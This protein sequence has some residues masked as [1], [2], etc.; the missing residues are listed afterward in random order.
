VCE[1]EDGSDIDPSL[2]FETHR[3]QPGNTFAQRY[4]KRILYGN[5]KPLSLLQPTDLANQWHFEAVFDYGEHQAGSLAAPTDALARVS[6]QDPFSTY[7]PGFERRTYRL[8]RRVLMFHRFVEL[9][10]AA[11]LVGATELTHRLDPAGSVLEKITYQGYRKDLGTGT[12]DSRSVP[13]LELSYSQAGMASSF[14]VPAYTENIPLG[15]DGT[16]YQ[17][18]DLQNEGL[19]GIL[20]AQH[21]SWRFKENLGDGHFGPQENV[22]ELPTAVSAAFQLQDFDGDGNLNLVGFEGREAGYYQHDRDGRRWE[23]FRAFRNL[24]RIDFANVGV[25]WVDLN[26]DRHPDLIVDRHERLVWYPSEGADGFSAPIE[27]AKPDVRAGGAPTLT[28]NGRL[29]TFFADMTGDGLLDMVCVDN[30]RIRYWPNLGYAAFGKAVEMEDA[31]VIDGIDQFD[32]QRIRFV[33]LDGSGTADLLYIG[34]GEIRFWINRS[35]NRLGPEIRLANLPYIDELSSAQVFDFLGDGTQC[36]VWS[37]PLPTREGQAIQYLRLTDQLPPRLLVAVSNS[38]GRETRLSYRSSAREYLRDKNGDRTWRTLLP[39]HSMIV[40]QIE[41]IDHIGGGRT[42][43]RFEYRDGYFDDDDRRFV[44]F[45]CVDTFDSDELQA[46]GSTPPEQVSPPS[47]IRS[48]CHTGACD[49]F[50]ERAGDFYARDPLAV[51]LPAPFLENLVEMTTEEQLDA[52]RALA[53]M[54]WRQ[55]FYT[56]RPDGTR[57]PHPIRTNEYAFRVRREQPVQ[58]EQDAVFSFIQSESLD[59]EYEEDPSDPR[60][61]HSVILETDAYGNTVLR[62]SCAYPRRSIGP[63]VLPEQQILHTE[64]VKQNY[65]NIDT[66][67]RFE[68]GIE[69]EERRYSLTGLSPTG[70]AVFDLESLLTQIQAALADPI[71]FHESAAMGAAQARL[72][73]LRRNLFWDDARAAVA[74]PGQI[75][76]ITLLHHVERAMLPEAAVD[77]IYGGRVTGLML[78]GDGN[79]HRADGFWWAD[80]IIYY[81]GDAAGFYRHREETTPD[82][83]HQTYTFDT[84]SLMITAIDDLFGNR[85]EITPDYQV[86]AASA[87][88]D[89]NDNISEI[90]YDPLGVAFVTGSRGQQLGSDGNAHPVGAEDLNTYVQ[91]A[92]VV[93]ADVL[94]NPAAL[95]QNASRF[96]FYDLAAFERGDG[97]P[98][99][100][101]LEREQYRHDGE[102]TAPSSSRIRI[103]VDYIDGFGR[104]IQTKI[105]V[106]PGPAIQ[107][108][109]SGEIIVDGDGKPVLA[110]SAERWLTSGHQVYNNKGWLIRKYESLFTNRPDFESDESMQSY[111]VATRTHYDPVGRVIREDIPNGSFTTNLYA[112]WQI[113]QSDANDNVVGSIYEA[114]RYALPASDPEKVALTKAQAHARTPTIVEADPLGRPFRIREVGSNGN[115]R[116]TT[117]FYADLDLPYQVIDPRRLTALT[118]RYDMLGNALFEHSIDAGERFTLRNAR[119]QTI[120]VW[121]SR[122]VHTVCSYDENGRHTETR[123]DGALGLDNIVERFVYGDNPVV[124]RAK[125]KN[126]RGRIVQCFDDAGILGFD[127][128]HMGGQPIDVRRIF[129]TAYNVTVDWS[130]PTAVGLSSEVHRTQNRLDGSGRILEQVLPD[131]TTRE[132]EYAAM[133]HI[134]TVR[135]TTADGQRNRQ[136][137]AS[138]IETNARG[139]RTRLCFGNGIETIYEYDVDTFRLERLHTLRATGAAQDYLDVEYTYDPVGNIMHWIDRVQDPGASTPIIQ[140]LTVSSACEFTYDAFYQLASATGRVHQALLQNDY[141]SGLSDPNAIK[142][143]RHLSLNNGAAV[144]RYTRT[145]A[146]DQA[147]NIQQIRHQGVTR[148]WTTEIW[149]SPA[150]N[151]SLPKKDLNGIDIANPEFHFDENGNTVALPH[152]RSMDWNY[153]NRLSRAVIID[154]SAAGGPDDAEYY[155]YS[156]DGLRVRRIAVRLV[157]G[158]VEVTETAYFD[159]CEIRRVSTGGNPH[160]Y[161]LSPL[162]H[163]PLRASN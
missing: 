119:G 117:T 83:G 152:L 100:I 39:H 54:Q 59:Y 126:A 101:N 51:A 120:D 113:H 27:I 28:Q 44:A 48:W 70:G 53:G 6:R 135:V 55:E 25:Q 75:G 122:D 63:E 14:E 159:G 146:Y 10:G 74:P 16:V 13:P 8:C 104:P 163:T 19:P 131:G 38:M 96:F 89:A 92:G 162:Q 50:T 88:K 157:A 160:N 68:A 15:L 52:Y 129:R 148:S 87:V 124:A 71:A 37:T 111:G 76:A 49:G 112:A 128:Y 21:D 62:A 32:T 138:D 95:L 47:L 66:A 4:L 17:W 156:A 80:D 81:Y 133:G 158:Q 5:S 73:E 106:D 118:Y 46:S 29:H 36:L 110:D 45:G 85:V 139:Q 130:D 98:R 94:A 35:G 1:A 149:T 65:R 3:V 12:M 137:I 114:R 24:P 43:S 141:R 116:I 41:D 134:A 56:I 147:G 123:V 34:R 42:A 161:H 84:Y 11:C 145:F 115:D 121:D 142:G 144:E 18:V 60:I 40:T 102:G 77:P 153:A 125:L 91:Q 30:G 105:R 67:A 140:G 108:N 86:L 103:A 127:R 109:T 143:T 20:F 57:T 7:R 154:R 132:Y 9:G 31:P 79:Y 90:R 93:A 26:G 78:S 2:S 97:P 72:I 82:G 22:N 99:S 69:I 151:R 33:D 150:S 64:L 107:R 155:V 23:G 61:S 58:G 136:V